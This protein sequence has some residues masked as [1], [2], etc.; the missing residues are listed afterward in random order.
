MMDLSNNNVIHV[1]KDGIQYLQFKRLLEYDDKLKHCFTMKDLNFKD[2]TLDDYDYRAICGALGVNYK[3]VVHPKQTHTSVVQVVNHDSV[4]KDFDEVDGLITSEG[5][6]VLSLYFADCTALFLY[7]PVKNVIGNIHSGWRG[8]VS[9]IGRIAVEK[10][11]KEFDCNPENIICC[12][13]PTIRQCH[14]QVEEDVKNIFMEAFD[15]ESIIKKGE[16]VDGK[17]K[18]YIDS[19]LANIKM[20]KNCGLKEENIIDSEICTVCNCKLLHSYRTDHENAG[21]N[22][23]IMN[24]L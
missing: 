8:T 11:I 14:F 9:K 21:R 10:M 6:K 13:G 3:S 20:L 23:A 7:D 12:I 22:A 4:S 15:D 16:V 18:Y 17:Q 24:L 19:V 5:N 1:V 2:K